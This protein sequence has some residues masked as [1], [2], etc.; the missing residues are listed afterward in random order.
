MSDK[1]GDRGD[2]EDMRIVEGSF[3]SQVFLLVAHCSTDCALSAQRPNR[4]E[5]A[6]R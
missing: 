2:A 1:S 5:I 6:A 4:L 3:S